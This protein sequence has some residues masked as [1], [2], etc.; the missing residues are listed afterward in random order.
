MATVSLT[1]P[2]ETVADLLEQLGGI[3][4][5][6]VRLRP[7][8]GTATEDDVLDIHDRTGRIYELVDGVLVEKTMGLLESTLASWIGY[9]LQTFLQQHDLGFLAGEA[10]ATRLMPGLVRIPD[11]S[12]ISWDQLPKRE[13]PTDPLPD[14]APALAVEVLSEGNTEQEMARKLREYFQSGVRLVWLVDP[15]PRTVR[16][17]TAPDQSVVLTEE[18]TLD[19]GDVLPGLTLPLRTVF[20]R[21]PP[22]PAKRKGPPRSAKA[23]SR[24]GK[25]AE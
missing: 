25:R 21:V 1:S 10:G 2:H 5:R 7:A 17:Y 11:V 13:V 14:L 20:S 9:L 8:P 15:I 6:R 3:D 19:G 18:Q 16:V 4:P 22:K 12:F 24:K 23:K